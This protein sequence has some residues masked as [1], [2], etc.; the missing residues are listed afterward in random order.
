[1]WIKTELAA[2]VIGIEPDT[3]RWHLRRGKFE[4]AKKRFRTWLI[5]IE[6]KG[7][8][9]FGMTVDDVERELG[10]IDSPEGDS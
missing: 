4:G 8:Q 10:A 6:S 1:M 9:L 7:F 2:R 5:P 3:L